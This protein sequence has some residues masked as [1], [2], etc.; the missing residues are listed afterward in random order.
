MLVDN[1]SLEKFIVITFSVNGS[2]PLL[3]TSHKTA[4]EH[5]SQPKQAASLTHGIFINDYK[6]IHLLYKYL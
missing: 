2:G 4:L 5:Y 6:I 1:V 3:S